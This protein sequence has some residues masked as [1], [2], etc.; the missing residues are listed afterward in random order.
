MLSHSMYSQMILHWMSGW[1]FTVSTSKWNFLPIFFSRSDFE[2]KYKYFRSS[3]LLYEI[4]LQAKRIEL[5]KLWIV[6]I[7]CIPHYTIFTFSTLFFF[8]YDIKCVTCKQASKQNS[9]VAHYVK[10]FWEL[11]VLMLAAVFIRY[12]D[13]SSCYIV[14]LLQT[15]THLYDSFW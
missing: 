7:C 12:L 11:N 2:A 10:S 3:L 15:V 5:F 8:C 4:V 9:K 1:Y 13:F 6:T 14:G